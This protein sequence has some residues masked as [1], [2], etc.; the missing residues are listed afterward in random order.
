MPVVQVLPCGVRHALA[1]PAHNATACNGVYR[2]ERITND[3]KDN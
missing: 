1:N 2:V 3:I